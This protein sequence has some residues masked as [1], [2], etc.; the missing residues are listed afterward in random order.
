MARKILAHTLNLPK[1]MRT[2]PVFYIDLLKLD[3]DPAQLSVEPLASCRQEETGSQEA[4]HQPIAGHGAYSKRL[5]TQQQ[6][7][8]T[9]QLSDLEIQVRIA[10]RNTLG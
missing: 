1:K 6:V 5:T 3:R 7:E 4:G 9:L 10:V 8:L 2:H